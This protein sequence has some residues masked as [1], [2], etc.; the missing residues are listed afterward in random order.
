MNNKVLTNKDLSIATKDSKKVRGRIKDISKEES[1]IFM[2]V[3]YSVLG[4]KGIS[5]MKKVTYWFKHDILEKNF[6]QIID[7][8][9]EH[10]KGKD[11]VN[12]LLVNKKAYFT[13]IIVYGRRFYRPLTWEQKF[14]VLTQMYKIYNWNGEELDTVTNKKYREPEEFIKVLDKGEISDWYVSASGYCDTVVSLLDNKV[15]VSDIL[16]WLQNDW[17]AI[18]GDYWIKKNSNTLSRRTT[19]FADTHYRAFNSVFRKVFD[20]DIKCIQDFPGGNV[21]GIMNRLKK[22]LEGD[23]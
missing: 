1:K 5:D 23:Y 20:R 19:V 13:D 11:M 6:K 21:K 8:L 2:G 18:S 9:E 15:S 17:K 7:A 22:G 16:F 3:V 4:S 12:S 14:I 10:P